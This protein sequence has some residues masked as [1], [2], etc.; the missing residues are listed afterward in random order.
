MKS[1]DSIA[2]DFFHAFYTKEWPADGEP[3]INSM[4]IAE[5]YAVQDLVAQ[6]IMELGESIAGFNVSIDVKLYW[7]IRRV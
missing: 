3:N 7:H 2:K 4:S 6:K 1:L 5:A